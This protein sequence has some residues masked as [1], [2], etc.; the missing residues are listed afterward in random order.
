MS[1]NKAKN[2][3]IAPLFPPMEDLNVISTF[4]SSAGITVETLHSK[5]SLRVSPCLLT[6]QLIYDL[7]KF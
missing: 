1:S 2:E 4:C 3:I 6:N 7:E 5:V